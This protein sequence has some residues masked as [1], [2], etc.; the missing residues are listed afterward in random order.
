V[1][2][3]RNYF[4]EHVAHLSQ[5]VPVS[6]QHFMPQPG[7]LGQQALLLQAQPTANAAT[8]NERAI[9]LRY[10]I[11]SSILMWIQHETTF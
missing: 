2:S 11:A 3:D 7:L 1:R 8:A 4:F 9:T 5:V 10:F 6:V